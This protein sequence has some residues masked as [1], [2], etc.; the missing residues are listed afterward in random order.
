MGLYLGLNIGISSVG[1]GIVNDDGEVV[2]SGVR[3]FSAGQKADNE[4]RRNFRHMRRTIRRKQHRLVRA[5]RLFV[6]SGLAEYIEGTKNLDLHCDSDVTPYHLRVKGLQ[7]PLSD[8]ELVIALRH[9]LKHRGSAPLNMAEAAQDAA[10]MEKDSG[11]SNSTKAM[12][13]RTKAEL[14]AGRFVCEIQLDRLQ[15]PDIAHVRG[16]ENRFLC[17]DY[18]KEA[19]QILATQR[20]YNPAVTEAFCEAYMRLLETRRAYYEGPG[21]E[22]PF[23]WVDEE[24]WMARLVGSCTYTGETR[25][26][27]RAPSA[28]L[29]NL[30][31]DLNNCYIDGVQLTYEE[32]LELVEGLFYKQKSSPSVKKVLKFLG[33]NPQAVVTGLRVDKQGKQIF[34]EL[35]G[36]HYIKA[37]MER[38]GVDFDMND[39]EITDE[40]ARVLSVFQDEKNAAKKL[41]ALGL[42]P[43]FVYELTEVYRDAKG[44]IFKG[45]HSLSRTAIHLILDD[46]WHQPKNQMQLF[47]EKGIKPKHTSLYIKGGRIMPEI[48]KDMAVSAV[49]RR[50]ISQ[51]FTVFNELLDKYHSFTHVTTELFREDNSPAAKKNIRDR[52]AYNETLNKQVLEILD[53]KDVRGGTFEKVRLYLIQKG[54]DIYTGE[55][56]DLDRVISEPTYAEVNHIIP[57]SV[58]FDNSMSNKGLT[59]A[60]N[61]RNKGAQTPYQWMQNVGAPDFDAFR[62]RIFDAAE[63]R[64]KAAQEAKAAK[65]KNQGKQ[66]AEKKDTKPAEKKLTRKE[67]NLLSTENIDKFE[68]RA[69]YINRNLV[70]SQYA[71]REISLALKECLKETDTVAQTINGTFTHYLKTLWG[72]NREP[73]DGHGQ[74]AVDALVIAAAPLV[75]N[76]LTIIR[77]YDLLELEGGDAIVVDRKTGEI[78]DDSDNL[79]CAIAQFRKTASSFRSW[80]SIK[81]SH[82]VDTKENRAI[83]GD[84]LISVRVRPSD[85]LEY[86]IGKISNIYDPNLSVEDLEK[87]FVKEPEKLLIYEGDPRAF[88]RLL[89]VFETYKDKCDGKKVKNPFAVYFAEHGYVTK[90]SASGNGP[91]IK[92]LKYYASALSGNPLDISKKQGC[93]NGRRVILDSQ[94]TYRIDVYKAKKGYRICR[95]SV[96]MTLDT[97]ESRKLLEREKE[98]QKISDSDT[99]LFSLFKNDYLEVDGK[100]Y[101]YRGYDNKNTLAVQLPDKNQVTETGALKPLKLSIGPRTSSCSKVFSDALGRSELISI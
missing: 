4:K 20:Q 17:A 33:K 64:A 13:A 66:D 93:K 34:T 45:T 42:D 51:T 59:L 3:L 48:V 94:T 37:A 44:S 99:F 11:N 1:Y 90:V 14:D 22:S 21:L 54:T 16:V 38:S 26:V 89:E 78:I 53:G 100:L 52:Q 69:G 72:L 30:L 74:F 9:L 27:K 79:K 36:Y 96:P 101:I 70:D 56:L 50:A 84:S 81:Y 55:P 91:A 61:S 62:Q 10:D 25:I 97:E 40:I 31:N 47:T 58:S 82:K 7:E 32:K 76:Q 24:E 63:E 95:V 68:V 77:D 8:K 85:G 87:Y 43:A 12:I 23:S 57:M 28:E 83:S 6:A 98:I 2:A 18:A 35:L 29:F 46:L 86:K 71:A 80:N 92:S 15:N 49:A 73:V 19:N 5:D 75:L 65:A 67:I 88:G 39:L 60:T 41:T